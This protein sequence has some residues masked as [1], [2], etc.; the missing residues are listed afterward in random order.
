MKSLRCDSICE[1]AENAEYKDKALLALSLSKADFILD[2]YPVDNKRFPTKPSKSKGKNPIENDGD[3]KEDDDFDVPREDLTMGASTNPPSRADTLGA[4][5]DAHLR[6]DPKGVALRHNTRLED[7]VGPSNT[8]SQRRV[9]GGDDTSDDNV[10]VMTSPVP[11]RSRTQDPMPSLAESTSPPTNQCEL[12]LTV[13]SLRKEIEAQA[14]AN[15][16]ALR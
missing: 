16:K 14:L 10:R 9:E 7:N 13:Q 1:A 8:R 6:E 2:E 5:D 12:T 11:K 3:D 15:R 4:E